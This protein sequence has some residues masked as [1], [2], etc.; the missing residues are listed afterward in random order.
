M[1]SE[2]FE[3]LL[4]NSRVK[5]TL[6]DIMGRTALEQIQDGHKDKKIF[7]GLIKNLPGGEEYQQAKERFERAK[8]GRKNKT[9]RK[10]K[11]KTKRKTLTF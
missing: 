9:K 5:S 6:K 4:S 7:E 8:G 10:R 11:N 1:N 2:I 3:V